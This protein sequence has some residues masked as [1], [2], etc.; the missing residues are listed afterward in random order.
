MQIDTIANNLANINTN[1]FKASQ[2]N[3]QDLLYE[4]IATAGSE[5]AV[6]EMLPTGL[7]VGS[8]ARVVSSTKLFHQGELEQTNAPLDIAIQGDG[9]FKIRRQDGSFAYTRD[10]NFGMDGDRNLVRNDGMKLADGITIPI[11]YNKITIGKDGTV[12]VSLG[13][14]N[15]PQVV[16]SIKVTTFPN[17]SGLQSLGDNLFAETASSGTPIEQTPGINGAGQLRQQFIERSNVDVVNAL[18]H[19]ITAQR[20]YEMNTKAI[21]IS[22][23]ILQLSNNLVR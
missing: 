2:V 18:V 19:L 11:N 5:S 4:T 21:T 15:S 22:D 12:S 8:G 3:F 16:G 10:G 14:D 13:N 20:A 23:R 7:E 17:P 1:G 6:G 9:F